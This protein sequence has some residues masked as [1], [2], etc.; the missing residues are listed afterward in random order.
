MDRICGTCT[1]CC[2]TLG[3]EELNKL[4]GKPCK[5]QRGGKGCNTYNDRPKSCREFSCEWLKGFGEENHRP[6]ITKIVLDCRS[7]ED[8]DDG[9]ILQM[10]EVENGA[11]NSEYSTQIL[12]F[13]M[14]NKFW[15]SHMLR[16]G[17]K[18]VFLPPGVSPKIIEQVRVQAKE[19]DFIVHAAT[20]APWGPF[21]LY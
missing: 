15:V 12:R 16:R 18:K 2:K 4:P 3:V 7:L 10:W 17:K 13:C 19:E 5:H 11:L 9:V 8:T 6:N 14:E 20:W 1:A 21:F